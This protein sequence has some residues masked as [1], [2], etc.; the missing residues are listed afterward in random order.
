[1]KRIFDCLLKYATGEFL[2]DK[3]ANGGGLVVARALITSLWI[4]VIAAWIWSGTSDET[5][6]D[7]SWSG[8]LFAIHETMA[9]FGAI[10]AAVYVAF[11]ARYSSQWSYLAGLYNQLMMVGVGPKPSDKLAQ[12][13][14]I[15]WQVGFISDAKT[16]HLDR[17]EDFI[18]VVRE[19]LKRPEVYREASTTFDAQELEQI[20]R[21]VDLL[22]E[23]D[24]ILAKVQALPVDDCAGG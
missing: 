3:Y 12:R 7:L 4:Y 9:W 5:S 24:A 10:F 20:M 15:R 16:L 13:A 22:S 19:Y 21:R 11:Y 6:A 14:L 1:M 2:L 18:H 8:I 17:K 23:R